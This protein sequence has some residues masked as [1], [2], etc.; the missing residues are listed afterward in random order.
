[1]EF[2]IRP[3]G[4]EGGF[5]KSFAALELRLSSWSTSPIADRGEWADFQDFDDNRSN[6]M[7]RGRTRF[8]VRARKEKTPE[9]PGFEATAT[10]RELAKWRGQDLNRLK[11]PRANRAVGKKATQD[12]TH[13]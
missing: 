6:S 9:K 5:L 12:P 4:P 13:F 8:S 11:I 7:N 10:N 1:V 3:V 2:L